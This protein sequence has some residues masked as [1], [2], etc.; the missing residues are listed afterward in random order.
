MMTSGV[1]HSRDR[2]EIISAVRTFDSF[3]RDNDPYGE[4]DFGSLEINGTRYFWKID[5]YDDSYSCFQEDGNRVL[6]IG[7]MDEY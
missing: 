1:A 4:H 3:T 5:Y 6:T 2:D 7:R